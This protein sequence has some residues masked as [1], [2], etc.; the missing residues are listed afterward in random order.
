MLDVGAVPAPFTLPDQE[1]R[2]VAWA[3][4]RG[5][6]VVVFFYPRAD[7]PGCTQEACD[8]RDLGEAFSAL[9]VRVLGVSGDPVKKQGNFARKHALGMP[10]LCDVDRVILGAWGVWGTKMMYGK[11]HEGI[12]RSTFL[13]DAEGRVARVW[14][15]VKVKGHVDEVLAAARAWVGA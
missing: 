4:L 8:F 6:P 15:P 2:E 9:G 3:S 5:Q 13:F 7:T 11:P 12:I 1:G 14:S 10:L